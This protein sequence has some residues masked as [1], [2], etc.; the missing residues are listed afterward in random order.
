VH[1]VATLTI[2][3]S[4]LTA[5]A[6]VR[7]RC[8]AAGDGPP[9]VFL[10]G[11]WGYE[12]YPFD[13]QIRAFAR[14]WRIVIPDRTNYGGSTPLEHLPTDFHARA[15]D[16]TLAV[17]DALTIDRAV[18]WGHSDGAIIALL[19]ALAR[20]DRVQAIVAEATHFLR[21]KPRSR[22]FFDQMAADPASLGER[23]SSVLAH[24]HGARWEDVIR[25]NAGAWQRIADES[26]SPSA[27]LY[28]GRLGE[29]TVPTLVLHGANDPRTEP[30]EL[31]ALVGALGA[32]ATP[33][34]LDQGGHSPHSE[35]ASAD[36][37]IARAAAFLAHASCPR[38]SS[39]IA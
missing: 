36:A 5:A 26:P 39:S 30:G 8:R 3:S 20:P 9:L 18:L 13:A 2:P 33:A 24:D 15:A 25:A 19:L 31:P 6:P 23:V 37:A 1:T 35:A 12:I 11:G 27:D 28:D 16:E 21:V 38:P 29:L 22:G 32:R 34:V 7:I 4:P 10:H 14:D 17:L